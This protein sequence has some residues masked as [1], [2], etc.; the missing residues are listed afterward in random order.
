MTC[1]LLSSPA[2]SVADAEFG[3]EIADFVVSRKTFV[4]CFPCQMTA[5]PVIMTAGKL[6]ALKP[7]FIALPLSSAC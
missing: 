2:T 4:W 6:T 5:Q 1:V 7:V 3:V